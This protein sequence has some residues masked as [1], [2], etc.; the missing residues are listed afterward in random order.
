MQ[1][2]LYLCVVLMKMVEECLCVLYVYIILGDVGS[3]VV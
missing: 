3:N 1:M 2:Y